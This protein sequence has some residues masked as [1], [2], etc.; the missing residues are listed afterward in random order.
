MVIYKMKSIST[1]LLL[2]FTGFYT[3]WANDFSSEVKNAL[4]EED[5]AYIVE[6]HTVTTSSEEPP[7]IRAIKGHAYLAL[8]ENDTSLTQFLSL[9]TENERKA[10]LDLAEKFQT[11]NT[12]NHVANYL[13]GDALARLGKWQDAIASYTTALTAKKDFALALNARGIAWAMSHEYDKGLDDLESAVRVAPDFA[14]ALASLGTVKMLAGVPDTAPSDY[15][16]AINKSEAFA[17][18]L[19]G[20]ACAVIA[21]SCDVE[22]LRN[23]MTD[24]IS[25]SKLHGIKPIVESNIRA[26]T[27]ALEHAKISDLASSQGM[28]LK[29]NDLRFVDTASA[30]SIMGNMPEQALLGVAKG[31]LQNYQHSKISGEVF[32]YLAGPGDALGLNFSGLAALSFKHADE[33]MQVAE[34]ANSVLGEK[35]GVR[36]GFS[37][38]EG[39]ARTEDI[40]W[41]YGNKDRLPV[42]T[43]FGLVQDI[44]ISTEPSEA[45]LREE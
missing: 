44:E 1:G 25:A 26:Y 12:N 13:K 16:D 45:K 31:A 38:L 11:E 37:Q 22:S 18:A 28:T 4:L 34:S 5:W 33:H 36:Q 24:F 40:K 6:F 10:W 39:G 8:N 35:F 15:T 3:A 32:Q 20:R 23:S 42:K 9:N 19:N 43:W 2:A 17:L 29:A 14:D 21:Y 27:N 7:E 41:G 30:N